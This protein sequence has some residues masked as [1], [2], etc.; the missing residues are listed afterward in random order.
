[1]TLE[2]IA[3]A[4]SILAS[5][6]VV[7]TLAF[8]WMQLRQNASLMRLTAA[9]VSAQLLTQ[10]LARVVEHADLAELLVREGNGD[11]DLTE[12]EALRLSNF[13]SVSW[14]N[15][16]VLHMHRRYS[17]FEEEL[18][19]AVDARIRNSFLNPNVRDWWQ[20]SRDYYAPSFAAY[21]DGMMASAPGSETPPEPAPAD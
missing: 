20:R 11:L 18:W 9:Q 4:A 8:I 1:M 17:A 5:L 10:N 7:L 19:Q 21:V 3:T 6:A 16:E 13:L 15:Y 14:R 2:S 12:A